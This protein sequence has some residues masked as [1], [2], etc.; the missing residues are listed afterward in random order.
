MI[1]LT[2]A[3]ALVNKI[4]DA[5]AIFNAKRELA[6]TEQ[7]RKQVQDEPVKEFENMFGPAVNNDANQLRQP[8]SDKTVRA[9][10]A[11]VELDK[12]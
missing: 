2:G 9:D 12:E 1:S 7:R 8:S 4:F 10:S 3:I 5:V 6:K 11:T